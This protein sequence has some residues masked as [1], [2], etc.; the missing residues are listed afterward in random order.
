MPSTDPR[1]SQRDPHSRLAQ[2]GLDAL[3]GLRGAD[4]HESSSRL[5]HR[6]GRR[7]LFGALLHHDGDHSILGRQTRVE[8]VRDGQG[9]P[10]ELF[11]RQRARLRDHGRGV[12]GCISRRENC[13]VQQVV[14]QGPAVAFTLREHLQ[15]LDRDECS[16]RRSQ[17]SSEH[18][19]SSSNDM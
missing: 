3:I 14:R 11:E 15:L 6:Q 17:D 12:R 13:F 2:D 9:A 4:R 19:S 8:I 7:D 1:L 10:A 18:G 5:Q 16:V